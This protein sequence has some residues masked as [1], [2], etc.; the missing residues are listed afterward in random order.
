MDLERQEECLINS[1]NNAR[2]VSAA[3]AY[4]DDKGIRTSAE[5]IQASLEDGVRP[6]DNIKGGVT[7]NV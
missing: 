3:L 1:L 5:T 4:R 2:D 6:E 7:F